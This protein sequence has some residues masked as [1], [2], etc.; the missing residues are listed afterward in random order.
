MVGTACRYVRDRFPGSDVVFVAPG[1][2]LA[3]VE[4]PLA[5]AR[6]ARREGGF[7]VGYPTTRKLA[8]APL[9][10]EIVDRA[11]SAFGA[12]VQFEF[13]GWM[14]EALGNASNAVLLPQV[15]DYASYLAFMIGRGWDVAIA[16]L[17]PGRFESFKTD[18][19]YRE[20]GGC[21]IPGLYSR[22][23]PYVDSVDDGSTGLLLDNEAG[24]WIDAIGRLR[25]ARAVGR[26]V[27]DAAFAD[28]ATRRDIAVTGRRFAAAISS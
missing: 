3:A 14:P 7:R 20:Y 17:M 5:A 22:V 11:R 15:D 21:R 24:A 28:I 27:S 12:G 16:P 1:F 18:I 19:K 13:M 2:D 10:C 8:L 4:R 26:K 9:L 25:S 23:P 6:G